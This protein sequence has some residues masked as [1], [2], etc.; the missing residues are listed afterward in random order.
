MAKNIYTPASGW[1]R[2]EDQP[3]DIETNIKIEDRA[4]ATVFAEEAPEPEFDISKLPFESIKNNHIIVLIDKYRRPKG[5]R[6]ILSEK[7]QR[8]STKGRVV[9]IADDITDIKVGDKVLYSQFG[10]Y[11]LAFEGL[12]LMRTLSYE[13]ILSTLKKDAPEIIQEGN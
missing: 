13:E 5:R 3:R 10:G 2:I 12:P 1:K 11:L 7:E 9:A 4:P 6:V 8:A